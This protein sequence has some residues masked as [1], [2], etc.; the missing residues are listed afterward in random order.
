MHTPCAKT[1][2]QDSIFHFGN[3]EGQNLRKEPFIEILVESNPKNLLRAFCAD[4]K[5]KNASSAYDGSF[6]AD[7]D[8]LVFQNIDSLLSLSSG[9]FDLDRK[10]RSN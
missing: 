5:M 6:D 3:F 1:H 2:V 10:K 4:P 9:R 8:F 7:V